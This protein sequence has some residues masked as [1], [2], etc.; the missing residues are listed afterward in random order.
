MYVDSDPYSFP[1]LSGCGHHNKVSSPKLHYLMKKGSS[2]DEINLG[3]SPN[4][5]SKREVCR[6]YSIT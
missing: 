2:G 1:G 4:G 5:A 3:S 6:S